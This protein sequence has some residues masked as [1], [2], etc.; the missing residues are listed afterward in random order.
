MRV[1]SYSH[2]KGT[3]PDFLK[4]CG[5]F[6]YLGRSTAKRVG[7]DH[8]PASLFKP[9]LSRSCRHCSTCANGDRDQIAHCC[10]NN[11][12][13]LCVRLARK[14]AFADPVQW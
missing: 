1:P 3:G 11:S 2:H 8:H 5:K 12:T 7:N 13:R 14:I 9:L 4:L 6:I 10:E